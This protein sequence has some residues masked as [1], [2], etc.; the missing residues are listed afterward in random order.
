MLDGQIDAHF[1]GLLGRRDEHHVA[2]TAGRSKCSDQSSYIAGKRGRAAALSCAERRHV[3]EQ[4]SGTSRVSSIGSIAFLD[5][6]RAPSL[7]ARLAARRPRSPAP[8]VQQF[9]ACKR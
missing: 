9:P 5:P 2:A 4:A 1:C 7:R 8:N 3:V 6:K